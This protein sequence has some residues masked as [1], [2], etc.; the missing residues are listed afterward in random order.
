MGL[1]LDGTRSGAY[2]SAASWTLLSSIYIL[3]RK[4]NGASSIAV[5]NPLALAILKPPGEWGDEG[6]D[7]CCGEGQP[8]GIPLSSGG[9][10]LGFMCCRQQHVR[11][12][13]GR[14]IGGTEEPALVSSP[15]GLAN[16][17]NPFNPVTDISYSLP[18]A[19]LVKL[20]V[21]NIM[22][23]EI[24]TLVDE[25][26]PAGAHVVTWRGMTDNGQPAASGVYFYRLEAADLSETKKMLL[27]K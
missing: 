24:A 19:S 16:Y 12:M 4:T 5:V 8:L 21:Y 2:S 27:L 25:Y 26:K 11:Q 15:L 14:I 23:Q 10:Y 20:T 7:I 22:G 17:P 9:P 6:V 1:P 13:P 18:T 3:A